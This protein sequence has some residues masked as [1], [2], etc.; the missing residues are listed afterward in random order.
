MRDRDKTLVLWDIDG[1]LVTTAGAGRRAIDRAFF[2]LHGWKDATVSLRMD[3]RTDPWIVEETFRAHGLEPDRF[4][5]A[6]KALL[7][8]YVEHLASELREPP[9]GR[10]FGPLPG[11]VRALEV[12]A[13]RE[14]CVN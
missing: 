1:T 11:V 8:R 6:Q 2:E 5:T 3:G 4:A 14:D 9:P 7:A 12:L 10:P 13:S